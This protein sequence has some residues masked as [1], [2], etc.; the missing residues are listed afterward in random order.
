M[1]HIISDNPKHMKYLKK[2]DEK[3]NGSKA[4]VSEYTLAHEPITI[5]CS[6]C[7]TVYEKKYAS[8][9]IRFGCPNCHREARKL[10]LAN[11][12]KRNQ[13]TK[14]FTDKLEK[15]FDGQYTLTGAYLGMKTA[16]TIVCNKCDQER[17][18]R[19]DDLMYR[20]SH[21]CKCYKFKLEENKVKRQR[22]EELEAKER[23]LALKKKVQR[24]LDEFGRAFDTIFQDDYELLEE[25][26]GVMSRIKIKHKTCGTTSNKLISSI[27]AGFG[28][29][30]CSR[31]GD[32]KAV[33]LI[34]QLLE[35]SG[36]NY[37]REVRFPKCRRERVLPFDIGVYRDDELKF[38]IE[39]DGEHHYRA[40]RMFGGED[41]LKLVRERDRIKTNFC[42][43][44]RIPL[45]RIKF[46]EFER[47]AD[48]A[49][50]IEKILKEFAGN[51]LE[52]SRC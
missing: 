46:T 25:Y 14:E 19:P 5:Y 51:L 39:Y 6:G 43:V 30:S 24:K 7:R 47:T 20:E 13:T 38:L 33:R 41:K 44:N 52:P 35:E 42:E 40:T 28:C 27:L 4:V 31:S 45:L 22:R 9:A 32:S 49:G 8:E 1:N 21:H 29:K 17:R 12:K 48:P 37:R 3:W 26:D 2:F 36:L 11:A 10:N 23:Q 50:N 16:T 18:I 34:C 15:K